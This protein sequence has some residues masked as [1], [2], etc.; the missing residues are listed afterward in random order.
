M[1]ESLSLAAA[2]IRIPSLKFQSGSLRILA[3]AC[4][5]GLST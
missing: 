3:L 2:E 4:F 5:G 1:S